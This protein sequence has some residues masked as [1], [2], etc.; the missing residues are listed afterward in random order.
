[1]SGGQDA[2]YTTLYDFGTAKVT[3]NGQNFTSPWSGSA[4]TSSSIAQGL[5]NSFSGNSLVNTSLSG[6][7]ITLTSQGT[8]TSANYAL[9]CSTTYDSTDFSGS[10]FSLNCPSALS[11]GKNAI[12][13]AGTVIVTVNGHATTRELGRLGHNS[14]KLG[15][16]RSFSDQ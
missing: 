2:T 15:H 3:V 6:S 9:S 7:T 16:D 14:I 12:Y 11:G 1:M 10:S 4:T 5:T 8:G 13:D